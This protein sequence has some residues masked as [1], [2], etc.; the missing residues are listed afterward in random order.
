ML[1]CR[2]FAAKNFEDFCKVYQQNKQD[3][4]GD[5]LATTSKH[6]ISLVSPRDYRISFDNANV[7]LAGLSALDLASLSEK[8]T[9]LPTQPPSA[10]SPS[11]A[12]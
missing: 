12:R 11:C 2:I 7:L 1:V 8:S 10:S 4:S 9:S 3:M 5:L 6:I